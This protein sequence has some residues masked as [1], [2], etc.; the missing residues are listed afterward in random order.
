[1][2]TNAGAKKPEWW[3]EVAKVI[4]KKGCVIFSVDGFRRNHYLYRQGVK[5]EHVERNMKAFIAPG[6]R[7]RWDYLIFEHSEKDVERAEKLAFEWGV[8]KFMKKKTGRFITQS[9][10][11]KRKTHL[12]KNPKGA[13]MQTLAKIKK[14][15]HQN[16]A[17]LKQ[18]EIE[19]T[20]GGMMNYYNP[21]QDKN[22][23]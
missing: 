10:L 6:G 13:D 2:N 22:V 19:K 3:A 1:M 18:K 12:A 16:L 14:A 4:G 15:E 17:L 8:E 5:W 23:K 9:V 7:A 11:Q 20:Y 21:A